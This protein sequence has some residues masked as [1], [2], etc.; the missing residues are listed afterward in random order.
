MAAQLT[1]TNDRDANGLAMNVRGEQLLACARFPVQEHD[2][3]RSR[4]LCGLVEDMA[5]RLAA[6]DHLRRVADDLAKA[7][8]R[9]ADPIASRR[10]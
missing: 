2:G 9:A 10:S 8:V 1:L 3:V 6:P 4:D 7:L 5:K